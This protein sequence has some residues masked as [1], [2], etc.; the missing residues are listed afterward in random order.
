MC[1]ED[2]DNDGIPND[3]DNCPL[4]HNTDQRDDN[5]NT[6]FFQNQFFFFK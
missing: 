4:A 1:D 3:V 5:S 6:N 2:K